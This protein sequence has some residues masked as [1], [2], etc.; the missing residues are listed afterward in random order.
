[1]ITISIVIPTFNRPTLLAEALCSCLAQT[2]LPSEIVVGDDSPDDRSEAVVATIQSTTTVPIRYIHN[3]P[4]LRQVANVNMLFNTATS[5]KVMLLHDDDLLLP[6]ALKTLV[7]VFG[8]HKTVGMAFGKQYLIDQT[9]KIDYPSSETF[10]RDFFRTATYEGVTMTPFDAGLSQQ[11]PNNGYLIDT[12]IARQ[13]QYSNEAGD[14]CDFYFGYQVGVAGYQTYFINDYLGMYRL[15]NESISHGRRSTMAYH[16]YQL[17]SRATPTTELGHSI[18]ALRLHER[19]PIAITE[20]IYMGRRQQALAILLGPWYRT[21]LL[22]PR[23]I[24]RLLLTLFH[25]R[26]VKPFIARLRLTRHKSTDP[27][28]VTSHQESTVSPLY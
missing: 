5:D 9:G 6:D 7:A 21:R 14:A 26:P 28:L 2:H 1:M 19:A 24:K 3:K 16:A 18:R 23:G 22:T 20:A 27:Q 8:T 15:H 25:V 12:A 4:G 17:L 13:I 11:I 10:N